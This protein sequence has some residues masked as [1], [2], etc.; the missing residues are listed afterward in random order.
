L[1]ILTSFLAAVLALLIVLF[2]VSNRAPVEITLWPLPFQVSLGV[3]AV[4]LIA[5]LFG[6][7]VGL[8]T[9][10][11]HGAPQRRERRRLRAQVRDLEKSLAL[12]KE[13][14]APPPPIPQPV[15]LPGP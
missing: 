4:T 13:A 6:F 9:A 5:V 11:L 8:V 10:W 12:A 7:L 2:A 15:A 3:Y 1:R 14:A